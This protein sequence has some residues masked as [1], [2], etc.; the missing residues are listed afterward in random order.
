MLILAP[1][2][3][4]LITTNEALPSLMACTWVAVDGTPVWAQTVLQAKINKQKSRF[5]RISL[6]LRASVFFAVRYS[7]EI[8]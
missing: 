7:R 3:F 2:G 4:V 8:P 6:D 5:T 1:G